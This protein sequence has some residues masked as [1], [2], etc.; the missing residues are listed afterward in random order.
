MLRKIDDVSTA[1]QSADVVGSNPD[2]VQLLYFTSILLIVP[3]RVVLS[4]TPLIVPE[5][6]VLSSTP[7]I[8]PER[9][10][11]YNYPSHSA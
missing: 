10:V 4:S 3:E 8:V 7:L 9:V 5:R 6:V 1:T 2:V 11:L